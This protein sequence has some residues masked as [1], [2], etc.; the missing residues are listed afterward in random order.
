[1]TPPA[2]YEVEVCE[3][4]ASFDDV[5]IL[6]CLRCRRSELNSSLLPN[7]R[8]TKTVVRGDVQ[9]VATTLMQEPSL[10]TSE[11]LV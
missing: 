11:P 5:I 1:V 8:R 10:H 6:A 9:I 7:Q 4:K 3:K 2:L